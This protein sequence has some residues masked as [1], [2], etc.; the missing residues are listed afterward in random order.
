MAKECK[1]DQPGSLMIATVQL[2]QADSR[3][4]ARISTDTG[5][6]FSTKFFI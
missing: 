4:V 2:M 6:S 1:H 5:I 3:S